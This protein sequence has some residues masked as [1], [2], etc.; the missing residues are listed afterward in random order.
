MTDKDKDKE[1]NVMTDPMIE[2]DGDDGKEMNKQQSEEYDK[3]KV[4]A[5][6][7]YLKLTVPPILGGRSDTFEVTIDNNNDVKDTLWSYISDSMCYSLTVHKKVILIKAD[8][9]IEDS[10][11]SESEEY[12]FDTQMRRDNNQHSH[13][14]PHSHSHS[15]SHSN[16]KSSISYNNSSPSS[17]Q[18]SH[19][20]SITF[21]KSTSQLSLDKPINSQIQLVQ[22]ANNAPFEAILGYVRHAFIPYSK[23]LAKTKQDDDKER[24]LTES[25]ENK[26]SN[27][28]GAIRGVNT[29]LSE[30]EVELLRSQQTVEIPHIILEVHKVIADFVKK[31]KQEQK[32][33]IYSDMGPIVTKTEF[34]NEIQKGIGVW[35]K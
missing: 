10:K 11:D 16:S 28:D 7:D 17:T 34:L 25:E 8:R 32:S 31:C 9:N 30:L 18:Y 21:I 3:N 14:H 5:L 6:K 4:Q 35:K 20:A 26:E 22:I 33:P 1:E 24:E 19:S 23:S 2:A 29:K 27:Q 15:H 12:Y 13:S